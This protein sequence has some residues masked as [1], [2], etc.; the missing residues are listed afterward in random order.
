[1]CV[2]ALAYSYDHRERG[3]SKRLT[4]TF[5]DHHDLPVS[6]LHV[7][8]DHHTR[9]EISVLS[10]ATADVRH[11]TD[12]VIAERGVRHGRIVMF[13]PGEKQKHTPMDENPAAISICAGRISVN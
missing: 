11:L 10:G 1:M 8:F 5:H 6:S 13:L 9:L 3:L 7:H 2:A 12:H 4:K